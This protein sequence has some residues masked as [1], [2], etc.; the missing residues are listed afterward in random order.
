MIKID[1]HAV[2]AHTS[3]LA[4]TLN[5]MQENSNHIRTLRQSLLTD[6]S[7]AAA[8]AFDQVGKQLDARL[9]DYEAALGNVR[10]QIDATSGSDGLMRITDTNNGNKFLSL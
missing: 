4:N 9:S 8:Q 6:Y 5:A 10:R 3:S 7:G 2:D 1:F